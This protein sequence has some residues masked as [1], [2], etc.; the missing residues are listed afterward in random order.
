MLYHLKSAFVQID[1]PAG[2]IQNLSPFTLEVSTTDKENSG[3]LLLP[4]QTYFFN[5]APIFVRCID[6]IAK[7]RIVTAGV[8]SCNAS[9]MHLDC[10]CSGNILCHSC[11]DSGSEQVSGIEGVIIDGVVQQVENNFAVLDLSNYKQAEE[12]IINYS[13]I[14]NLFSAK[15]E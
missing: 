5:T 12:E 2:I 8:N 13:D 9:D 4:H 15:E 14:A 11:C 7:T 10:C 1:E 3:D 6:G